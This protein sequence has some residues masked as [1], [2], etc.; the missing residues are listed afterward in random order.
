[1]A[2]THP[3][4]TR[5][6]DVRVDEFERITA[7]LTTLDRQSNLDE[8]RR[9]AKRALKAVEELSGEARQC[10]C[11][12]AAVRLEAAALRLRQGRETSSYRQLSTHVHGAIRE[13][14]AGISPMEICGAN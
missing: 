10:G 6:C 13:I 12:N 5:A 3:V 4:S 7:L 1:M 8:E 2:I 9:I 11:G 14:N